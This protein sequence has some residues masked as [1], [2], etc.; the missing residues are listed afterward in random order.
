M[1]IEGSDYIDRLAIELNVDRNCALDIDYLRTRNR[2]TQA[3]EDELIRLHKE[4]T[5]PNIFEFGCTEQTGQALL[6]KALER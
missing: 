3:L 4:G 2:H 6:E 5:P 1:I